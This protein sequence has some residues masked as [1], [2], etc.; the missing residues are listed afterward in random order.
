[1]NHSYFYIYTQNNVCGSSIHRTSSFSHPLHIKNTL[2]HIAPHLIIFYLLYQYNQIIKI[3]STSLFYS[4]IV[5]HIN[6]LK[7]REFVF[8]FT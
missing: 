6:T 8:S 1:M 7:L 3:H 2:M 5:T 4:N